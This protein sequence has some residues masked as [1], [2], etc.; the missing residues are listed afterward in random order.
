MKG[1]WRNVLAVLREIKKLHD[2]AHGDDDDSYDKEAEK[3]EAKA[4]ERLGGV[5]GDEKL[6]EE[7]EIKKGVNKHDFSEKERESLSEKKSS[8]Q[9]E[10]REMEQIHG[11]RERG[12]AWKDYDERVQ[13]RKAM[14]EK[15]HE[16]DDIEKQ[17]SKK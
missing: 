17:L 5:K 8:L 16:I 2:E 11:L 7:A 9:K 1:N 14:N 10:L 3:R 4:K 6:H 13:Y 15:Q 12:K